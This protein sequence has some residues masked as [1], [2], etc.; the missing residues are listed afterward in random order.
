MSNQ[1][2]AILSEIRKDFAKLSQLLEGT[3]AKQTPKEADETVWKH[4]TARWDFT[5]GI[6]IVFTIIFTIITIIFMVFGYISATNVADVQHTVRETQAEITRMRDQTQLLVSDAVSSSDALRD[7]SE[8]DIFVSEGY[9]ELARKEFSAARDAAAEATSLITAALRLTGVYM[10]ELVDAYRYNPERCDLDPQPPL[11]CAP[12]N[13]SLRNDQ[14]S[15]TAKLRPAICR[16]LFAARDLHAKATLFAG[17]SDG[18]I[19]DA[20]VLMILFHGRPEGYHWTGVAEEYIG[21]GHYDN[22]AKCFSVSIGQDI[23]QGNDLPS[24]DNV[25]L[26]EL[27]FVSGDYENSRRLAKD[28]LGSR[29]DSYDRTPDVLAQ[30]YL[31][32]AE[33]MGG[34]NANSAATFRERF[35]SHKDGVVG[36]FSSF[37][38][39]R[40]LHSG[41]FSNLPQDQRKEIQSTA[42]C[43]TGKKCQ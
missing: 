23:R 42:D 13:S 11:L 22:A 33:Y 15:G 26:A 4:L 8:G 7:L 24:I 27:K 31:A 18:L 6:L 28:Y 9:R 16:V 20:K 36:T 2:A 21:V 40:Y 1:I 38:L 37:V 3:A 29:S 17:K 41:R 25:N 12:P 14:T 5:A 35:G 10:D 39:E 32:L 19:D 30:F 34:R 43:L